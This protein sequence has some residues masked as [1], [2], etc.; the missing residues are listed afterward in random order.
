MQVVW[1]WRDWNRPGF[2]RFDGGLARLYRWSLWA[3]PIEIRRLAR[4]LESVK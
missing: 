1:W 2:R 4:P 3:G